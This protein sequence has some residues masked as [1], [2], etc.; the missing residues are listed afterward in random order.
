MTHAQ[1]PDRIAGITALMQARLGARGATLRAALHQARHQL[2]RRIRA[3]AARLAEAEPFAAHP[4]LRLTLDADAL[5]KA[6]REVEAHLNAID[7]ADRRKGWWLGMLGGLV[8]N[9]LAFAALLIAVLVW[10]GYL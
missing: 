6:A 4:R 7:L 9:M 3:Q 2:P 1:T 5:D 8:F 10:R